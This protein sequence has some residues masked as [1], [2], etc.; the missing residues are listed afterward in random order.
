MSDVKSFN[1]SIQSI[2]AGG[3]SSW[4]ERNG[5]LRWNIGVAYTGKPALVLAYMKENGNHIFRRTRLPVVRSPTRL[6]PRYLYPTTASG[7]ANPGLIRVRTA[8]VSKYCFVLFWSSPGC[9][10]THAVFFFPML[11][12]MLP[13]T[14]ATTKTANIPTVITMGFLYPAVQG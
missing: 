3:S 10:S 9:E 1:A 6:P 7:N 14:Q 4:L 5:H 11:V 2:T 13:K 8:A 12:S